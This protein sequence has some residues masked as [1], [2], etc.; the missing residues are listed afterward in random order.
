M[1]FCSITPVKNLELMYERPYVML[2][3]HLSQRNP[4]Y[5]D[6]ARNSH[7]YKIM[8]N[9]IIELGSAFS[10]EALVRE[11][12]ACDVDEIILPDVF[13]NGEATVASVRES[14]DWLREHDLLGR[15]K[16]MAVCHGKGSVELHH[17]FRQLIDMP[18]ID[19]IGIPKAL[20]T[21]VTSRVS[22]AEYMATQTDKAIHLLGCLK[23][24]SEIRELSPDSPIRS[25][26]TC[27]PALL[28][29]YGMDTW[30]DRK[31]KTIDLETA[32]MN[33]EK[34]RDII[35]DIDKALC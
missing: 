5:R 17:T 20:S 32:S 28:S 21:W 24:L 9:S 2:L 19:V 1:E 33:V 30:D 35:N 16:L 4:L 34:Y 27:L 18:E 10:M 11:A 25:M 8:D 12:I 23:S 7:N 13:R 6:Y 3:A 26:D 22:G 15:F 31:G 14:I 29:I